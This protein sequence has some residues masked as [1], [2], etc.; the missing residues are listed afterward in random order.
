LNFGSLNNDD[1]ASE[2]FQ[3][4][5]ASF[6]HVPGPRKA[7]RARAKKPEEPVWQLPPKRELTRAETEWIEA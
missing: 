3:S 5:A 2:T 1:S 7:A 4:T 6:S